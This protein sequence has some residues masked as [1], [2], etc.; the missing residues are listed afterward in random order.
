MLSSVEEPI[1]AERGELAKQ[2]NRA[3]P[4]TLISNLYICSYHQGVL[5]KSMSKGFFLRKL[6]RG[7]VRTL[8]Y[9]PTTCENIVSI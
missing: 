4:K 1:V 5:F 7:S 2:T 9:G 8:Y 6:L 3:R